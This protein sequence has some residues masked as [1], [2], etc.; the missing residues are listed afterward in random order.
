MAHFAAKYA[1]YKL[2]SWPLKETMCDLSPMHETMIYLLDNEN[3]RYCPLQALF[4]YSQITFAVSTAQDDLEF[5]L[6]AQTEFR[7]VWLYFFR[8]CFPV[9]TARNWN[10]RRLFPPWSLFYAI[11]ANQGGLQNLIYKYTWEDESDWRRRDN[12]ENWIDSIRLNMRLLVKVINE[13]T[14]RC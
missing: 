13:V 10:R 4:W 6:K 3:R 1:A 12:I 2:E 5:C 14:I 9:E 8:F 7:A 11:I